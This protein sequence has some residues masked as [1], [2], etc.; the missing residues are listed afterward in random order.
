MQYRDQLTRTVAEKVVNL[1]PDVKKHIKSSL[2][3]IAKNPYSGKGLQADL[4]GFFS[5]NFRRYRI[6]Y[7]PDDSKKRIIVYMVGP[8]RDIYELLSEHLMKKQK[9]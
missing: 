5:Y 7:K 2:I 8:R 3:D 1:H 9:N 4:S 6:I